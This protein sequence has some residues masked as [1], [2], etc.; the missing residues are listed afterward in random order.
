M[1]EERRKHQRLS[2]HDNPLCATAK[3]AVEKRA[4]QIRHS[5]GI[6][7]CVL[8]I[9]P[10]GAQL[11]SHL[12]FP[13]AGEYPEL[14]MHLQTRLSGALKEEAR[15]VWRREEGDLYRYGVEF[16]RTEEEKEHLL[17]VQIHNAET[18]LQNRDIANMTLHCNFC[19]KAKCPIQTKKRVVEC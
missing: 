14:T 4:G 17:R 11:L 3:L 18:F 6:D 19:A 5:D 13:T 7:L 1:G 16:I 8:N 10:G 9:S 15:I 2:L 12:R